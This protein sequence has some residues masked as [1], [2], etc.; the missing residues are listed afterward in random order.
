MQRAKIRHGEFQTFKLCRTAIRCLHWAMRHILFA[1]PSPAHHHLL[2]RLQ[3]ELRQRGH[4][5]STLAFDPV[6]RLWLA[7]QGWPM[8][9]MPHDSL[10]VAAW[11]VEEFAE[12]E[13]RWRGK[14]CSQH[15][16][17]RHFQRLLPRVRDALG[18]SQ[19]DL[20]VCTG[21]RDGHRMLLQFAAREAGV[22][23]LWLGD[24]LLPHTLQW[25]ARGLDGDASPP[26]REP[27]ALRD[28]A[29][30]PA[31]LAA[32]LAQVLGEVSPSALSRAALQVPGWGDRLQAAWVALAAGDGQALRDSLR[33]QQAAAAPVAVTAD[34]WQPPAH[35]HLAVL[36]QSP[37][38]PRL[39]LDAG[40]VPDA[41][42]L[43][44]AASEA[45]RS[46][47][48]SL[49][50]VVVLPPTANGPR[51]RM[52]LARR[53]DITL[54]NAAAVH[55]VAATAVATITINH[56][57]ATTGLLAG[58]PVLHCGRALYGLP[59]VTWHGPG[60]EFAAGLQQWLRA[61]QPRLR[62][63][64]LTWLLQSRHLWCS[65][66]DPDHNGMLGLTGLVL[67]HAARQPFAAPP[68]Y[69][70]G[71]AWPLHLDSLARQR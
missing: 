5:C 45:A 69:R 3:R 6:A 70:P 48:A 60:C 8:L 24:G 15:R 13:Q 14:R 44:A 1:A 2:E 7:Q 35:P 56:P 46:V 71:P 39:R 36:L 22:P 21:R 11:Q 29:T 47:D 50:L 66:T 53:P 18:T 54:A 65:P 43:V 28:G 26:D 25:D 63:R 10:R 55:A 30:A 51:W 61:P 17:R 20:V 62:E 33:W 4:H 16:W 42:Q 67:A 49:R 52:P 12:R 32:A 58:T 38:D 59:G 40:T 27:G 34:P 37:D 41:C 19:P 64:F 9:T 31:L 68:G 23:V 57:A